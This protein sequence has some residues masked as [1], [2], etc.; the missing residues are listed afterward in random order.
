[1]ISQCLLLMQLM[2][3]EPDIEKCNMI[4]QQSAVAPEIAFIVAGIESHYKQEAVSS[5]GAVGMFQLTPI[6]LKDVQ[7]RLTPYRMG[8]R[9]TRPDVAAFLYN[10]QAVSSYDFEYVS[11]SPIANIK[12]GTCFL[13]HLLI[14]FRGDVDKALIYYNCGL[15]CVKQY[16]Q[17][18]PMNSETSTYII[19]FRRLWKYF[20]NS[21][22]AN[23][24]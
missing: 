2:N 15:T 17:G 9:S 5:A 21:R 4:Y 12:A 18:R 13:A 23:G 10:C 19:K 1:M 8:S 7:Q 24:D 6:A 16:E 20:R 22:T 3:V 11:L 14:R